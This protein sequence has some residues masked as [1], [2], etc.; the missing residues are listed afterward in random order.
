MRFISLPK[1]LVLILFLIQRLFAGLRGLDTSKI[2]LVLNELTNVFKLDEFNNKLV[3]DLSGGNKRKVSS[4][5]AF[6]GRP[7][8]VFLDEPTTGM[9]PAARRYLWTV[10]KNARDL[11]MTIVLTTHSMEECEALATKLGIMVNG[12]LKC[13][14]S[15]QHLKSKFGKG[16]TLIL[17][18]KK[19]VND[20][21][22]SRV[23]L[24]VASQIR[25]SKMKGKK[26]F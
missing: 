17:K 22:V 23:E 11:G 5:I 20:G 9:D 6:I 1:F 12:Q 7:S 21:D 4:A 19:S 18:C 25:F 13:L 8:V 26:T 24:F 2:D 14:G 16:Y 15:V 10:I 3:Q